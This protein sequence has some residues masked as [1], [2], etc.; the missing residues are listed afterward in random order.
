MS[1]EI[2]G[3]DNLSQ[4]LLFRGRGV[5]LVLDQPSTVVVLM[6]SVSVHLPWTMVP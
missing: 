1:L 4:L 5:L 3:K 2:K 6:K